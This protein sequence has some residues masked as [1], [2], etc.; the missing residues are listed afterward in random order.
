MLGVLVDEAIHGDE[1]P[2]LLE[3]VDMVMKVR[4][5]ALGHGHH[6]ASRRS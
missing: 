4:I 3:G 5:P 1:E 2:R 6:W